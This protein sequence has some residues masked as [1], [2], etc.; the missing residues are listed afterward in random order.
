MLHCGMM[1]HASTACMAPFEHIVNG[2]GATRVRT[3]VCIRHAHDSR[4]R[5]VV[6]DVC[7]VFSTFTLCD[8]HTVPTGCTVSL[9]T[10]SSTLS[11]CSRLAY[12][13][14]L[15]VAAHSPVKQRYDFSGG[16][17]R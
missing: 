11:I 3:L 6:C 1:P 2:S 15:G 14:A 13:Q 5:S 8:I 4:V 16:H 10:L 12:T 9:R 7:D 17:V